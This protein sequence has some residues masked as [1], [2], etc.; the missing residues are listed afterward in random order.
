ADLK[1]EFGRDKDGSI[2][3]ADSIGPDEFRLWVK[4]NYKPGRRQDS[5]D[6]QPVR[7]WLESVGY[8]KAVE[9]AVKNGK[10]IPPP[11]KLPEEIIREVSRRY[12]EAFERLTGEKFR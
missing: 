8:K 1:L 10:P 12:V 2:L 7:D 11:P 5:Y 4:A 9:E 6:K 3:L